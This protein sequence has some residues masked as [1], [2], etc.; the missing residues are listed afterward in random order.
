MSV[1]TMTRHSCPQSP[2]SFWPV[3]GIKGS[4]LIQDWKSMTRHSLT[5][6]PWSFWPVAGIKGSNFVQDWKPVIHWL[7]IKSGKSDWLKIRHKF[8]AHTQKLWSG[9]SPPSLPQARRI[10]FPALTVECIILK[11]AVDYWRKVMLVSWGF[12]SL[13]AH[14]LILPR[15]IRTLEAMGSLSWLVFNMIWVPPDVPSMVP[16]S[17]W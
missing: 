17:H 11:F 1:W 8:S 10:L 6:S 16:W 9:Q 14:S 3:A 15:P 12:F 2:W 5:Q 13:L 7:P 4:G